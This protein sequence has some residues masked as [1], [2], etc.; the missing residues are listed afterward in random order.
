MKNADDQGVR[1]LWLADKLANIRPVAG[2]YTNQGDKVWKS[3]HQRDPGMH[4]WYCQTIAK[5]LELSLTKT[6]AFKE[7][8]KHINFIRPGAFDSEKARYRKYR[9]ASIEGCKRIGCGAR[10]DVYR[11]DDALIIRVYNQN[12]TYRDV[13]R[14]I[15]MARKAFIP[16]IPTAISF[17]IVSVGDK[18]LIIQAWTPSVTLLCARR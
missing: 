8:I 16:D 7:F 10:G 11:H 5:Q 14:E 2:N 4:H 1:M 12:N 6:G 13:E 3:F 17:G 15:V 9:E 18:Q